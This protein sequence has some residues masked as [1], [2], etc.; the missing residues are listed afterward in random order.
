MLRDK[1]LIPLSRQHQ[2]ALAL[3]V[4]IERAS[5]VHKADLAAWLAK[6]PGR[7]P[8]LTQWVEETIEETFTYDKLPRQHHKHEIDKQNLPRIHFFSRSGSAA[9]GRRRVHL[10]LARRLRFVRF[11]PRGRPRSAE[12]SAG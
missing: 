6:W 7:Y 5:P 9:C 11:C 3:C 12:W 10:H 2:H 8:R 1:C 4:R